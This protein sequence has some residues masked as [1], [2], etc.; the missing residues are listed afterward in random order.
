LKSRLCGRSAYALVAGFLAGAGCQSPTPR[1]GL[2]QVDAGTLVDAGTVVDASKSDAG[3][4]KGGNSGASAGRGGAGSGGA[5]ASGGGGAGSGGAGAGGGGS[6]M[7]GNDAGP[8]DAGSKDAGL[9]DSGSSPATTFTQL[10]EG[11]FGETPSGTVIG[12]LGSTCH[13]NVNGRPNFATKSAAYAVINNG[14]VNKASPKLSKIYTE[15]E[16][17]KMP[18]GAGVAKFTAADLS[19]LESWIAAGAK[20]D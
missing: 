15:V 14:L 2:G 16:S 19:K 12:C 1:D 18:R 17:G 20:N 8:S 3:A 6:G 5:G 4:G 13:T 9:A 7:S 10:Y 11:Y